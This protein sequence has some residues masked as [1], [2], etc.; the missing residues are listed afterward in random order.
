MADRFAELRQQISAADA[1]RAYGIFIGRNGMACCPFHS[2]R[3]P[4]CSFKNGFFHCFGCGI[5]GDSIEFAAR[6]FGI[7][8]IDA[9]KKLNADFGLGLLFGQPLSH[10][11]RER[12]WQH[13]KLRA[14]YQ[15]F[16]TWRATFLK[17]LSEAYRRGTLVEGSSAADL[18]PS[19]TAALRWHAELG[20]AIDL[21]GTGNTDERLEIY[22][23][24]EVLN[25]WITEILEVCTA[26]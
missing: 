18:S 6:L 9:A 3:T 13:E 25:R 5:G 10:V 1:A 11:E 14:D 17:R 24:R 4:S 16:E 21:L 23:E 15:A 22:K 7:S 19:D 2:D 20:R 26:R 12:L 8:R